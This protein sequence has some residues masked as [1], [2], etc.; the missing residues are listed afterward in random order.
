MVTFVV[1]VRSGRGELAHPK[2]PGREVGVPETTRKG[3]W[4]TRNGEG[5]K[6]GGKHAACPLLRAVRLPAQHRASAQ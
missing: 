1:V 5:V 6:G 3:S 2:R 4:R